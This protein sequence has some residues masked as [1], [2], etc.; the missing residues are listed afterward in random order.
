[1]KQNLF[2]TRERAAELLKE[3]KEI[4]RQSD[5]SES[6]EGLEND[7]VFSLLIKA[8]AYQEN[9]I[10]SDIEILRQEIV[11]D[12]ARVMTPFE[13]G[14]AVPASAVVE[15]MPLDSLAETTIDGDE[16]FRLNG[17][18][19]FMPLLRSKVF[20]VKV[21]DIERLDGRRWKVELEFKN[22]VT[23]L[24]GFSFA[25]KDSQY[26]S[27]SVKIKDAKL[28]LIRPWNQT[29]LPFSKYFNPDYLTYNHGEYYSGSML[30]MDLFVRQNVRM[31][32]IDNFESH[33]THGEHSKVE[34]VF[35]F[36]GISEDFVFNAEKLALNTMV[37]VNATVK[38]ATLSA[39]SPI[40]R[41]A[42]YSDGDQNDSSQQFLHLIKPMADQLFFNTGLE[43]RRV[44]GDR[45][46]QGSLIKL[47]N[48]IVNRYHSDFYAFQNLEEM[49][50]D[51][52]IF[53][54]QELISRLI[55]TSR[56][57][58]PRNIAGVYLL[59]HD[60]GKMKKPDFSLNVK[61]LTTSGS[62][63]NHALNMD[64]RFYSSSK[65]DDSKTRQIAAPVQGMDEVSSETLS[66]S[67]LKY[68]MVTGDRIVTPADI[69][70]FCLTELQRRYTFSEDMVKSVKV[71]RRPTTE[72]FGPGYEICTDILL[73]GTPMVRRSLSGKL[74]M[75]EIML[76]K[77]MEVR[78]TG[79]YPIRVNISLADS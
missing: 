74:P 33:N 35:E 72:N 12:F 17:E 52:L 71:D 45:F 63:V 62:A 56:R 40:V 7:P 67:L 5:Y 50:S 43:V 53:N 73:A 8:L 27:L 65:F 18:Y 15:T 1:M 46:N 14:H 3:A 47:L 75:L 42:G 16:E 26:K 31:Y 54:L 44:S 66:K 60:R 19:G 4:W 10:E 37:L 6:L 76:Q 48:S 41:I 70:L 58:L 51:K 61:Y 79:I 55:K 39:R 24:S 64:S 20:N 29:Q 23:N 22:P 38:E 69:K 59:L 36:T 32:W 2:E 30:P 68:Y 78:S 9:E 11:E 77:M 34:M 57:D 28:H 49:K 21:S 25:I 13:V